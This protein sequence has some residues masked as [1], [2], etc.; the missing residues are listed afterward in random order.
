VDGEG[1]LVAHRDPSQV[2][3]RQTLS[4]L[5]G[6]RHALQGQAGTSWYI[7]LEGAGVIG[8]YQPLQRAGW[9]VL[10]ESPRREALANVYQT[11]T[12]NVAALIA[13]LG[14]AALLGRYMARN[15]VRPLGRLREGAA[16]IGEGD[17]AHRIEIST[18]DE[19]G[20]LADAFNGMASQLWRTLQG[21]EQHVTELKRTE[22][23][24]R[25]SEE[26]YRSLVENAPLGILS[27][28]MQGRIMNVNRMLL[29]IL[30]S[31]SAEATRAINAFTFPPL[32][33]AGVA[34]D[35]HHCMARGEA[36]ISERYYTTKWGKSAHLR[37]H[38][39]PIQ[40]AAGSIAGV[41]GIVEDITELTQATEEL[42]KHHDH[43]EEL[44]AERTRELEEAQVELVRRERFSALGQLTATVAHEIRNPLGTV[45]TAVFAISDAIN[46]N[47]THRVERARQLA[48]RNILRC[49]RI[50]TELLDY[51][52]DRP[53]N[54]EPTW[55]DE[56]LDELLDEQMFPQ[57]I[58]CIRQLDAGGQVSID[59]EQ[60][61]CAVL[62]VLENA[63]DA[64]QDEAAAGNRLT[65]ST[66]IAV[67]QTGSRLEIR[68][69]DTGCGIPL[70][71]MNRV[72]EPLFS[73][74][75]VGVGLG[76]PTARS[77]MQQHGGGIEI[78]SQGEADYGQPGGTTVTLW[79]PNPTIGAANE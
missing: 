74:K 16:L 45:R 34:A 21:L 75:T 42:R 58:V 22:A 36:S 1:R 48:E 61:R 11:G 57:D 31:P 41:Q 38:L 3:R 65:V 78:R 4:Q 43:L 15:V 14:L 47:E 2:L 24:L 50:I 68:V 77:I 20:D 55:A 56:W 51:T 10:V 72:F 44:V 17:L 28:D 76:L 37:L 67:D 63:V 53:L 60:L 69:S 23:A 71:V 33:E 6:V 7:G 26:N 12:I 64:L 40:D 25:E 70:D 46:R 30:N 62:N 52:R 13:T 35:F 29:D 49:D 5:T 32:I 9:F 79:L 66:H 54:L 39:A 18:R 8:S 27:I 59:R 73:T 19:I